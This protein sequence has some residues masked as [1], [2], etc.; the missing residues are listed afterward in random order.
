MT[1]DKN[2]RQF[3][4]S[5]NSA[6]VEYLIVGG[7]AVAFHGHP[8]FTAD[9]DFFIAVNPQNAQAVVNAIDQFGFG[10]LGL[11]AADF[12]Q[13]DAIVQIGHPP[14]R[15]DLITEI[16][17]VAFAEAWP[18]RVAGS[19]DGVPVNFISRELLLRNKRATGRPKDIADAHNLQ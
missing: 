7:Y 2:L 12:L 11:T 19:L 16:S 10:S 5:L 15:I 9:I 8:R 1:L 17:A 18:T 14:N 13:P 4:E 3:I 6:N